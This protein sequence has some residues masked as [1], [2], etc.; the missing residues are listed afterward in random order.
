MTGAAHEA[1]P[2]KR[3]VPDLDEELTSALNQIEELLLEVAGW[4]DEDPEVA[5]PPP[6]PAEQ[7]W[8]QYNASGPRS[9]RRKASGPRRRDAPGAW[10]RRMADTS[11]CRCAWPTSTRPTSPLWPRPPPCLAIRAPPTMYRRHWSTLPGWPTAQATTR[12]APG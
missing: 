3:L 1:G 7:R 12:D 4:E 5:W 6:R 9:R 8:R 10:W 2:V 11:T